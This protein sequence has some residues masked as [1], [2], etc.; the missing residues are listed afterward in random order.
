ME[1]KKYRFGKIRWWQWGL[2]FIA[3]PIVVW[4]LMIIPAIPVKN[5]IN[6]T[7]WLSFFGG[8]IGACIT[9]FI[10]L[11]V[12]RLTSMHN[13]K[14]LKLTLRQNQTNHKELIELQNTTNNK[15][16]ELNRQSREQNEE[17]NRRQQQLQINTTL[18]VQEQANI[19]K[20]RKLS[21]YRFSTVCNSGQL[22]E[23]R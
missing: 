4:L 13:T 16:E 7:H 14:N 19:E 23:V 3:T 6:E 11:Y 5:L 8:Y 12:L 15:N 22:Y 10:T 1:D 20:L 18:Y 21:Y 2:L 9:G 17:L